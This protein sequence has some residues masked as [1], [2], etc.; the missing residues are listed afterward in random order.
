MSDQ[1]PQPDEQPEIPP[2]GGESTPTDGIPENSEAEA[3]PTGG[4]N[5][6]GEAPLPGSSI[7][8]SKAPAPPGAS[9]ENAVA[10][11]RGG[12]RKEACAMFAALTREEPQNEAAWLWLAVCNKKGKEKAACLKKALEINP[13]NL[14]T[15]LALER[16]SSPERAGDQPSLEQ[17]LPA[18]GTA[19]NKWKHA[20][21]GA[22]VALAAV[23]ALFLVSLAFEGARSTLAILPF[24]R[25]ATSTP[26]PTG[27]FTPLPTFTPSRPPTR[28]QTPTSRY[29]PTIT[30][31]PTITPSITP[32]FTPTPYLV[33]LPASLKTASGWE[34]TI[35]DAIIKSEVGKQIP[36]RDYFLIVLFEAQNRTGRRD[37]LKIDQFAVS[38]GLDEFGMQTKHLEAAKGRYQRDYPGSFFGQCADQGEKINSLLV[39]DIPDAPGELTL[40]LRDVSLKLGSASTLL[41]LTE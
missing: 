9:L 25:T 23:A 12:K 30:R 39:F 37:C 28:T 16:L 14:T 10:L 38:S 6:D 35:S 29:S 2:E 18:K 24:M 31:T 7:D 15:R 11:F 22:V 17:L 8:E 3:T 32:T 40:E 27:T 36:T 4:P 26:L 13:E 19:L 20:I 33:S 1:T 21:L 5:A 41:R 34:F